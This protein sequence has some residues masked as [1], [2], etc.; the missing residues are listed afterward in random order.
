[1]NCTTV[2]FDLGKVLLDFDYDLVIRRLAAGGGS[3]SRTV[4]RLLIESSLL[5]DYE[6][7]HFDSESFYDRLRAA[8]GLRMDYHGFRKQFADIFSPMTGMIELHAALRKRGIPTF[9]F[10]NTNEIAVTHIRER[11]PFFSGFDDYVFSYEIGAMKPAPAI[12]AAMEQRVGVPP[13]QLLYFD[14]RIE[15]VEAGRAR[16]W[17]AVV[18]TTV[19]QSRAALCDAGFLS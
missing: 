12:Y 14:D 8:L 15:N 6:M 19:E 2:I 17:R 9:I 3:D 10:S 7:G 16:G 11:Y 4:R 13:E 1:M 5:T 18:Q